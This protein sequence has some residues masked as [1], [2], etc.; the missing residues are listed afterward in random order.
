[1]IRP[2]KS[3]L[4]S[5]AT[6]DS[7]TIDNIKA[8][9][10]ASVDKSTP[11]K[12]L[13]S[14]LTSKEIVVS[15]CVCIG[16]IGLLVALVSLIVLMAKSSGGI[17]SAAIVL[18]VLMMVGAFYLLYRVSYGVLERVLYTQLAKRRVGKSWDVVQGVI[19][20]KTKDGYLKV[21]ADGKQIEMDDF[22]CEFAFFDGQSV[23]TGY[24]RGRGTKEACEQYE[25]DAVVQVCFD[26][27]HA[28]AIETVETV[29]PRAVLYMD[30]KQ[31]AVDSLQNLQKAQPPEK[32]Q[33]MESLAR[34]VA[35]TVGFLVFGF[36]LIGVGYY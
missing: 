12:L 2:K 3:Q 19:V 7:E 27:K 11:K 31:K 13:G 33:R 23:R 10:L 35:R 18:F 24:F 15:G 5:I 17:Y 21:T 14:I 36:A 30:N 26:T 1:M 25:V 29:Q 28:Y 8:R 9:P 6:L 34:F 22:F 32:R 20:A 4:K 16:L